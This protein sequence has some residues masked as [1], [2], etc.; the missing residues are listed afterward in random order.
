MIADDS[1]LNDTALQSENV[2]V[3]G[4][5]A[6][7][8]H[9]DPGL[10]IRHDHLEINVGSPP[11]LSVESTLQPAVT[12]LRNVIE[13]QDKCDN[14]IQCLMADQKNKATHANDVMIELGQMIS[15]MKRQQAE[16]KVAEN[17]LRAGVDAFQNHMNL[18]AGEMRRFASTFF[19]DMEHTK[20]DAE[21]TFAVN[22]EQ[23]QRV[24]G[25]MSKME[26]AQA[27]GSTR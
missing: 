18:T 12:A 2:S 26:T 19:T 13:R 15:E 20:R 3:A 10:N 17:E 16:S 8:C 7:R 1:L 5:R 24:D 21:S 11:G 9:S 6:S 27:S 25:R 14:A 23:H 4:S 22:F